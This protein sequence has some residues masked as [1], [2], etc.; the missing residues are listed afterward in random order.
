[1]LIYCITSLSISITSLSLGIFAFYKNP[2][3][4]LHRSLF[5]LNIVVAL[6]SFFL[7][8]HYI[9][10]TQATALLTS[11]LLHMPAVFIPA[12]FVHFIINLLGINKQKI[13]RSFYSLSILFLIL[14]P[15]PYFIRNVEPKMS[16]RFYATAGPL[17]LLWIITCI[18]MVGYGIYLL[19]KNYSPSSPIKKNQIKYV[20]LASIIGFAGGFSIYPLFYNIPFPPFGVHIIFLYPIVFTIAVLKHNL[21]NLNIVIKHTIVYSVSLALITLLYLLTVLLLERLLRNVVEYQSIWST[22]IAVIAIALIFTPLKSRVESIADKVYAGTA[23]KRFKKELLESDKRKVI[24]SLATGLA[25]EIRNPLT[26]I[27]TF[28]EYLPKKFDDPSF[29]KDF[30]QIVSTEVERINSLISQLLEFSK[31]S[32]LSMSA[33]NMHQLLDY[34]LK[35]LSSD[36]LKKDIR[37]IKNYNAESDV[38]NADNNKLK[39]VFFN[40]IKNS[41]DAMRKSGTLEVATSYSGGKF[42]IDISDDGIGIKPKDLGRIF[43]PFFS[44]K[45]KGTGLGLSIAKGIIEEHGGAI[46]VKSEIGRGSSFS[47]SL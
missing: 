4:P 35:L 6:W 38:V 45:E 22:I 47:V 20:L 1:M 5:S 34:N 41:I 12:C 27:K 13:V 31:P 19:I 37:L 8:L 44:A 15:T 29:R 17:Y 30:S 21:L 14:C 42:K 23:Y 18:S 2:K 24:A 9:S 16:F 33:V 36:M 25:H 28:S 7:F 46:T 3:N 10:R 26:A 11:R 39:H 40:I 43:E 32:E